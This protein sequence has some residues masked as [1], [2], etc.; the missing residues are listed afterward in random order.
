MATSI[1]PEQ[2]AQ[3][4]GIDMPTDPG[5]LSVLTDCTAAV[6]A[7]MVATVPRVR[8]LPLGAQWPDDVILGAKM[9]AGRLFTRRRSP[10]GVATF[11][12]TG[13]PVYTP[14]WDPDVERLCQTGA[15]APPGFA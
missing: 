11:T 1:T 5:D 14:R 8:A 7:E 13:G 2:V 15:W 12:E 6:N 4:L 9:M 10:T 3:Y